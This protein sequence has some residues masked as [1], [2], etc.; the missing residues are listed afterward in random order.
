MCLLSRRRNGPGLPM[1]SRKMG[2]V[3]GRWMTQRAEKGGRGR[4]EVKKRDARGKE[5]GRVQRKGEKA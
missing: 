2:R 3:E 4:E 1:F 5:E